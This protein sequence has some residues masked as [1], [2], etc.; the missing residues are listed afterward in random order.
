VG[1]IDPAATGRRPIIIDDIMRPPIAGFV[2]GEQ[3]LNVGKTGKIAQNITPSPGSAIS[4]VT[5]A[6]NITRSG[7]RPQLRLGFY[8]KLKNMAPIIQK[9]ERP[10]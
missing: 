5:S 9:L 3:T 10:A 6:H 8:F 7:S 4:S 1:E 2:G